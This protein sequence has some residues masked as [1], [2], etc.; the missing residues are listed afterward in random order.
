MSNGQENEEATRFSD[1]ENYKS[2]LNAQNL[3]IEELKRLMSNF[4][5]DTSDRK[6]NR[7]LNDKVC[8]FN[9]LFK[10]IQSNHDLLVKYRPLDRQ[11]DYF[12]SDV[13][14]A[15]K[16]TFTTI[17]YMLKVQVKWLQQNP[18]KNH[19]PRE[20]KDYPHLFNRKTVMELFSKSSNQE[21]TD[22]SNA[23]TTSA[24]QQ[25]AVESPETSPKKTMPSSSGDV[26]VQT[27][28]TD[29]VLSGNGSATL[30][31]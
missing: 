13:Y 30:K 6:T 14:T 8:T 26:T 28:A 1:M 3:E 12:N 11:Y 27:S 20:T 29:H 9:E 16:E 5:K 21:A 17:M 24:N 7:Y 31:A 2:L 18:G 23:A 15:V 25:P 19:L 10:G 4:L 22:A